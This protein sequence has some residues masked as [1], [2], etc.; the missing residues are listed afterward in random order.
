MFIYNQIISCKEIIGSQPSVLRTKMVKVSK[1]DF[2]LVWLSRSDIMREKTFS[3]YVYSICDRICIN[4]RYAE[5]YF[6][7]YTDD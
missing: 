4:H 3:N 5:N 7:Q 1:I 2:Q 6:F